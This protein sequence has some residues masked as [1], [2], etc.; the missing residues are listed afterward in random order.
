MRVHPQTLQDSPGGIRD[1]QQ[2]GL[3]MWEDLSDGRSPRAGQGV[4]VV[5]A[6]GRAVGA[7]GERRTWGRGLQEPSLQW[8]LSLAWPGPPP[9]V[10]LCPHSCPESGWKTAC[11]EGDVGRLP[12]AAWRAWK[13]RASEA[14]A[15]GSAGL[16]SHPQECWWPPQP[17]F[18]ELFCLSSS[19]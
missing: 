7:E 16:F 17:A 15:G 6:G 9:S 8:G 2:E 3:S 12:Q 18:S 19:F 4:T 1:C 14:S 10:S 13:G 11:W 5:L